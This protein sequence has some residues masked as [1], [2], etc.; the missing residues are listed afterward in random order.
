L[1]G[2]SRIGANRATSSIVFGLALGYE[3]LNGH[4]ELRKDPAC[5]V[6]AAELKP[7]PREDSVPLLR[8][9]R[10]LNRL[11]HRPEAKRVR[12]TVRSTP[13]AGGGRT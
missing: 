1:R 10:T 2:T 3:D 5:A 9:K 12:T 6:L 8:A 13:S 7:V 4:D 11:E